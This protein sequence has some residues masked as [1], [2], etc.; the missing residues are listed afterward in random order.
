MWI[1]TL[2]RE[3]DEPPMR[4]KHTGAHMSGAGLSQGLDGGGGGGDG[5][6]AVGPYLSRP[7]A[8][9]GTLLRRLPGPNPADKHAGK[10]E[11][12]TQSRPRR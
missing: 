2:R 3:S 5:G 12:S 4:H 11:T 6:G 10:G 1:Q 7:A 9:D 8:A